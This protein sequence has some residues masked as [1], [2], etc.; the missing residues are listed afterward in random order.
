MKHATTLAR[1][2][3]AAL[4]AA[5]A[6]AAVTIAEING[7]QFVSP[8]NG[9]D[10]TNLTGLVTASNEN[11]VWL[12]S[13]Q[14]DH[15]DRTSEGLYVFGKSILTSVKVGDVISLD[16]RVE[17]YRSN[18]NY[19]QLTEFS[20]PTNVVVRSSG[21][22]VKPLV[23]AV[24]TL[25][26]PTQDYTGLD[27]GG[28]FGV[29]NAVN[30]VSTSN[31]TLD[32]ARYGLD[33]WQSLLGELV[34]IRGAYQT[35]RPNN[36]GD[37]WVRG[38]WNTTG[39]NAHGGITMLEGDANPETIIIG[40]PL[41]GS[42]NP[43]NTKLG[44][45]LG[46]VTGVVYNAFGFYRLLPL[47]AVA[48][49]VSA[50]SEFPP[51]AFNSTG[52]CRG[53]T[54]ASYNAENLAPDSAHLPRVVDQIVHKLRL[55]DLIFLQEVQDNSGPTNN[56][57]VSASL[58]LTTL[59]DALLAES[60]VSY[61]FSNVDPVNNQDGGQVGGNIRQAYLYRND[62]LR[63]QDPN[64][65]GSTD[66]NQV[67][68]GPVLK[69]NPG[70]IDPANPAYAN[71]RKPLAA[72]WKTLRG[73]KPFFTVNVHMGSKGGSSTLHG[74]QR[75]PLNNGVDKR[76][77]QNEVA[78]AFIAEILAKDPKARIIA[79]G[80]FNEFAQVQPMR[81]FADKSGL[82]NMDDVVNTPPEERYSYLFDMNCQTLDHMYASNA[83]RRN[84]K[85]EHLHLNTWQDFD[86]QVSDHDPSV[87]QF[88]V[89]ACS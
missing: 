63:L 14:P 85:F 60:G 53:V 56:G 61:N 71:S 23:I 84:A 54:V 35:S 80:D 27:V 86:S 81:V 30:L 10:V 52:N 31:P 79:A 8:F 17:M 5:S 51:V 44:D 59:T 13:L 68:D 49:V 72:Q 12:R 2:L 32:P 57:V 21:N 38:A 62:V 83:L 48:P 88:N 20:R 70:R 43:N 46:D 24:D 26:P 40:S 77:T 37:V 58:T 47:T 39:I 15:D 36:F 69:Y 42:K 34:T 3:G 45:Y 11:G 7:N 33:F 76:T 29:P 73:G 16:G 6:A 50:S 28:I 19:I 64:Q 18:K 89:C 74:D 78:A 75:P 67:L 41:D 25:S 87:A 1:F 65:G 22:P 55:P 4:T 66:A 82:T 9:K